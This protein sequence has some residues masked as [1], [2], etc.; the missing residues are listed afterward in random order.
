MT[1]TS[2]KLSEV[3]E[4]IAGQHIASE[5]YDRDG[6]GSPYLTGPAD[7]GERY[8]IVTKWT[9]SPK[10]FATSADVLVTVKGAGVGKSN[11]G[12]DAAI[13]RQLMALRPKNGLLNQS[14]LF[15]FIRSQEARLNAAAQGAT[16]PGI[17]KDTLESMAI[18]LPSPAEQRRLA[19]IL[20]QADALRRKR[21]EAIRLANDLVPSLF[22]EMFGDSITNPRK[23]R[24]DTVGN[25]AEVQGGLQLSA[26]RNANPLQLPYLR[27]ANVHR[28]RLWLDEVKIIGLTENELERT[29]LMKDDI[30]VVEGHGNPDEIGRTAIWDGSIDPCV[31]QNH[32][33][34]VRA[35]RSQVHPV[36]LNVFLNSPAGRRQLTGFGKTTSGLNT[37]SVSNVRSTKVLIPDPKVQEKFAADD[38]Q[39]TGCATAVRFY[40]VTNR[41]T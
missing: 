21:A 24:Q 2:R 7:F 14:Y 30:L 4:I 36:Y 40:P 41:G 9:R 10:V 12:A 20:D 22:Y 19:D 29:R 28:D 6:E 26:A 5:L 18:P 23:W 1:P 38:P 13:G 15:A 16:V 35:D 27:V 8:P 34:R 17:G 39:P 33:I 31:H 3:C 32:L 37:I 11:L 25:I